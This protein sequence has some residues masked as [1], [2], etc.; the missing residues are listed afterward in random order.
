[1]KLRQDDEASIKIPDNTPVTTE[2]RPF[3]INLTIRVKVNSIN[4]LHMISIRPLMKVIDC[5]DE[6]ENRNG[7]N[8]EQQKLISCTIE[9]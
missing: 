2:T 6:A 7:S 8:I 5:F 1:M 9:Y 4:R 3:C